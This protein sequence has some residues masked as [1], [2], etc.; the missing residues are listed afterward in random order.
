MFCSAPSDALVLS[1]LQ[2]S[3]LPKETT[4]PQVLFAPVVPACL[5]VV[6]D[7]LFR[8]AS[9][10]QRQT[11]LMLQLW[12][13]WCSS[14][15]KTLLPVCLWCSPPVYLNILASSQGAPLHRLSNPAIAHHVVWNFY[16]LPPPPCAATSDVG[17]WTSLQPR[18][19][20]AATNPL[21]QISWSDLK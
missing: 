13:R 15:C 9:F 4:Q 10:R 2:A 20:S 18:Y 8:T 3:L 12:L 17:Q 16:W 14:P 5:H 19:L 7:V 1:F 6:P 11:S 21:T